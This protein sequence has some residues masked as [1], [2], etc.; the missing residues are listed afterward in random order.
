MHEAMPSHTEADLD[1]DAASWRYSRHNTA[2]STQTM[3]HSAAIARTQNRA[4]PA[5][6]K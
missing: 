5:L 4:G 3:C 1:I 2:G 6:N